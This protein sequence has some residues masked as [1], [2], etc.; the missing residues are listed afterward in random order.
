[1]VFAFVIGLS[2]FILLS[3]CMFLRNSTVGQIKL[4][5]RLVLIAGSLASVLFSSVGWLDLVNPEWRPFS[6]LWR[7]DRDGINPVSAQSGQ[8]APPGSGFAPQVANQPLEIGEPLPAFEA[9]GWLNG[10]PSSIE[11][12]SAKITVV[13][14]W[15]NWCP[16][17]NLYAPGLV[18]IHAKYATRGVEFVSL[19]TDPMNGVQNFVQRFSIPWPSGYQTS[20]QTIARFNA[21][22]TAM[23]VRGYDVRPTIYLIGPDGRIRWCDGH[24]RY[25]HRDADEALRELEIEIDKALR[26]AA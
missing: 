7:P 1:M 14:L 17:C 24:A 6:R 10:M 11:G 18:E 26:E 9:Q 21:F 3:V 2:G 8:L 12:T 19:T 16:Y 20:P 15:G 23:S 25:R 22:N 4:S 13:D 5:P